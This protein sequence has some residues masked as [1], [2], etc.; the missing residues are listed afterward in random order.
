MIK[1]AL[2]GLMICLSQ[3]SF[4]QITCFDSLTHPNTA[5][6]SSFRT[7]KP[8]AEL[9]CS[10]D[11]KTQSIHYQRYNTNNHNAMNDFFD[12]NIKILSLE[13][14]KSIDDH[15][16]SDDFDAS[17]IKNIPYLI[18]NPKSTKNII[19]VFEIHRNNGTEAQVYNTHLDGTE[20]HFSCLD[21][22]LKA[23]DQQHLVKKILRSKACQEAIQELNIPLSPKDINQL[24]VTT[25]T[26]N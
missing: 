17:Y 8:T 21:K 20:V 22:T 19:K 23:N 18:S 10:Q 4:A 15:L 1:L 26:L 7:F 3:M 16:L 14:S 6:A 24:I 5:K 13:H 9:T 2:M 12:I 25:G 11:S